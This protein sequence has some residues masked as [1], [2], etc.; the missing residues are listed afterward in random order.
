MM[1]STHIQRIVSAVG[2][3]VDDTAKLDFMGADG[4]QRARPGVVNHCD[5]DLSMLFENAKKT[6]IFPAVPLTRLP[7][8]FLPK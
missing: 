2:I 4:H 7:L 3:R 8:C 5:V 1:K 6:I